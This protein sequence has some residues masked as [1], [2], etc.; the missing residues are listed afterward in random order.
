M[1]TEHVEDNQPDPP[2]LP[3]PRFALAVALELSIVVT[4]VAERSVI[5]LLL[6]V[7][8]AYFSATWAMLF[9]KA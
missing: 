2:K 5:G 1:M 6:C 8:Y 4:F 3:D 7:A 9:G